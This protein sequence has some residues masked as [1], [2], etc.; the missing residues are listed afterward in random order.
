M[1]RPAALLLFLLFATSLHTQNL[2]SEP[3]P[4]QELLNEWAEALAAEMEEGAEDAQHILMEQLLQLYQNPININTATRE[5]LQKIFFLSDLQIEA[6]LFQRF[7]NKAFYSI[8][9]MQAIEGM[10]AASLKML[11]PLLRFDWE[12]QTSKKTFRPQA[13]LFIRGQSQLQT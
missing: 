1:K 10:D 6:L 13:D 2:S 11:A 12:A 3:Q 8:Y 7:Q 9:E 4:D 5:E